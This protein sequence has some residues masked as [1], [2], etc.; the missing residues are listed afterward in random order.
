MIFLWTAGI[1]MLLGAV[2]YPFIG[3]RE[4]RQRYKQGHSHGNG[5]F[6]IDFY[7]YHSHI[8][9]WNPGFKAGFAMLLLVLCIAFDH[10]YVSLF[11]I[12][13]CM[14]VTVVMGGLHPWQYLRLMTIPV[15]FMV[16]GSIAIALNLSG[17]PAGE[18]SLDCRWFYIYTTRAD[19]LRA[20]RLWGKAMGAVSAMYMMSLST[21]VSEIT[22]VLRRLH[23]PKMLVE[24]MNMIYR[25]IFILTD[26]QYKMRHSAESRLGFVDY[27]TSLKSFGR[28]LG[29]LFVVSLKKA[30]VYN[31]A[32]DARC[33]DGDLLFLEQ[34]KPLKAGQLA[35]AVAVTVYLAALKFTIPL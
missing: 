13:L 22:G 2:I 34:E 23:L 10:L 24:L 14:Y 11:I 6:S 32:M 1:L 29:N 26:L 31:D 9:G 17:S 5:V 28:I 12:A 15:A 21:P 4:Y 7:A 16:A 35:L 25:Y 19:L 18:Y 27:R 20:L 8:R 33:Y 3:K 30:R